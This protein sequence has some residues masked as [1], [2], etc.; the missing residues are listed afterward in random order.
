ML[1][2]IGYIGSILT[3]ALLGIIGGGGSILI[4]PILV[5]LF[6]ISPVIASGYSLLV[7]GITAA[8]GAYQ[9]YIQKLV[10]YKVFLVFGLPSILSVYLT[11]KY[12]VPII[13]DSIH[14]TQSLAFSKD[15]LVMIV[16]ALFMIIASWVMIRKQ[17]D[18]IVSR[19]ANKTISPFKYYAIILTEGL[20]VGMVTGF[21][22]AGGGFL[23]IPALVLFA[24][25]TMRV[26]VGTS[27]FIIAAKSLIG[28]IP[29]IDTVSQNQVLVLGV[30][31]CTALGMFVGVKVARFIPERI[32]KPVFGYVTVILG[33]FMLLQSVIFN[34]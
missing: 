31:I 12:I 28:F 22:G 34:A 5:F 14:L 2:I 8:F 29:E 18:G 30:I 4:F 16:F 33:I 13:P 9:Y 21:I 27:L 1:E 25:L 26:A 6:G 20:L 23:I 15:Q 32:L 17:A 19:D 3:G 11:R 7:V 24:G 10:N